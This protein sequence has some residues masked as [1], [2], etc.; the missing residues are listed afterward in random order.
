MRADFSLSP[1]SKGF[2]DGVV[3]PNF[4]EDYQGAAP[5]MGA[6][7]AGAAELEYGVNAYTE[8]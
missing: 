5:D 1:E 7:E 4:R 3:I 8:K 6:S 2:D